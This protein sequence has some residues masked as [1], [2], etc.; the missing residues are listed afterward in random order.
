MKKLIPVSLLLVALAGSSQASLWVD[1]G[2]SAATNEQGFEAYNASHENI[3]SFASASYN[4]SFAVTG[5][6]T[7]TLLPEWTNS[8]AQQVR[9]MIERSAGQT[10]SW[11]GDNQAMLRDWIGSDTRG[12]NGGNGS[13]DG[14]T[15]TPTYMTLTVGGLSGATYDM[16]TFHHDV[17]NMNSLFTIEVSTDGGTSFGSL[18]N[19]RMTNSLPGG[20]PAGNE[21]PAG[22]APNIGGGDPADLT[23]TQNFSF[24]ANGADDVV[25][26]FA[27]IDNAGQAVHRQFFGMNGFQLSQQIPEPSTALLGLVGLGLLARRRR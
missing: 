13:W 18:I 24:T 7:V 10:G 9:Q 12:G 5:A 11:T 16:T 15:G 3:A 19:G 27:A 26:R 1:F 21:V 20:S 17:E 2:R 8:T 22:T 6:A 14:T 4:T 25:L 23:S